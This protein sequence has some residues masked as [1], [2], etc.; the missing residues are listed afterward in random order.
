MGRFDIK[1]HALLALLAERRTAHEPLI[2]VNII[3]GDC[4]RVAAPS[5]D[6]GNQLREL[7]RQFS[8]RS[9]D[10]ES[11]RLSHSTS[12]WIHSLITRHKNL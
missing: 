3:N 11:L 12:A 10:L 6:G 1:L 4:N 2:F 7:E 9:L 5:E 8:L